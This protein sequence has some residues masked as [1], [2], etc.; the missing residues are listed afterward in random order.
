M[1]VVAFGGKTDLRSRSEELDSDGHNARHILDRLPAAVYMTD[2]AGRITYFNAAAV[3]L[4]GCTPALGSAQFCGSWK[5][6]WPDG[7]PLPHDQCP[8]ALALKRREPVRGMEAIAE[9][10]DGTR[11]RFAPYPTPLFDASGALTGAV[12]M[13]VD[14]T[15]LQ[16]TEDRLR[17]SERAAQQLAAIV[18]SAEDAI[19]SKSLDG[20][21]MSWNRGAERLFGYTA[22]EA[23]GQ[24]ITML[25][26]SERHN[27]E[28][29]ILRR[30]RR[31]ERVDHYDA[32]RKRKDGTLVP[33]SLTV[34]PIRNERGE[35]VGASK[36][37]RNIS[38]RRRAEET[39]ALLLR[40]MN[41]RVKNLF[42]LAGSLVS[43]STRFAATPK[44]L[45]DAV[46]ER[47][48]ALARAHTL[49]L[50]DHAKDPRT[51]RSTTLHALVQTI[52]S[53]HLDPGS[54][55]GRFSIGGPD[56]R[57]GQDA[58]TGLALL[59]HEFATNA[60]KYG[61]LSSAGGR[62]TV[63]W[64]IAEDEL[65][66]TWREDGGPP[67]SGEV[68]SEGFGSLLARSTLAQFGG[69]I[70]RDWRPEGLAVRL[71]IPVESLRN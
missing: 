13:L 6:Y 47:L 44:E 41:H 25:I 71:S 65:S 62:V 55:D 63:A 53:P 20:V 23:I 69:R 36:I 64:T 66:L 49:T 59:L 2:A 14:V 57:V 1:G 34:S 12:N 19:I 38:E 45:A 56:L 24:P 32:V 3:E 37:A 70:E 42:A 7:T 40:E 8:M 61:S 22:A 18:E 48:A 50:P 11:V 5:L 29:E 28:P 33:L 17:E 31:G 68:R 10:P 30:I 39:Q 52:L 9:R 4:W 60:A 21:I 46:R 58:V 26:P 51:D 15:A 43:L 27:E 35:V 67:I 54:C 16:R